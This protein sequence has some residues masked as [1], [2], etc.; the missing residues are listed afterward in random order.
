MIDVAGSPVAGGPR[1]SPA[2]WSTSQLTSRGGP[3]EKGPGTMT[4]LPGPAWNAGPGCDVSGSCLGP[5]WNAGAWK[6]HHLWAPA[7]HIGPGS[8]VVLPG[9]FSCGPPLLVSWDLLH[10]AA[11]WTTSGTTCRWTS[12]HIYHDEPCFSLILVSAFYPLA[13]KVFCL[14]H[15]EAPSVCFRGN[16]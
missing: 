16:I 14:L 4:M 1:G 10:Q 5:L 15:S 2:W 12:C 3:Q 9:P 11:H 8:A 13:I 6:W 7:F